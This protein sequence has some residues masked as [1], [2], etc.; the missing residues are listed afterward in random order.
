MNLHLQAAA[1]QAAGTAP[2]AEAPAKTRPV[3]LCDPW[4]FTP[5]YTAEL[6]R[7]LLDAGAPV[8]LLCPPYHPEPSFFAEQGLQ[9]ALG[10]ARLAA[11]L[12]PRR[13]PLRRAVRLVDAAVNLPALAAGL[14]RH[15][16]AILHLQQC[17]LLEHGIPADLLLVRWA[18][19]LGIPVVHT[20]HNLLPNRAVR[21][22][23]ALYG[24]FYRACDRLLCHTGE[25]AERLAVEFRVEA[26]R[27]DVVPHGPLFARRPA[28]TRG[29]CR[30]R[31]G[32]PPG[33]TVFLWQGVLVPYKG[34][35]LLLDAWR[36]VEAQSEG[37]A[38]LLIAGT[39]PAGELEVLRA[40]P[41]ANS[42][43][44]DLRYLPSRELP[45]YY[46]AAD[47]LLYPYERITTS[48]ALLTGLNY[49][50]PI[51]ASALPLFR[52]FLEH[53]ANALLFEQHTP[54]A[55][56]RAMLALV[57]SP[58]LLE[59]LRAGA[60]ANPARQTQWPAIAAQTLR[61][62]QAAGAR[63]SSGA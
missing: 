24:R 8:R 44:L 7:A 32:L 30:E 14:A 15:R 31:L 38:M 5:W 53:G 10:P 50:K 63:L 12:H 55:L 33:R 20:V 48:G 51:V 11:A 3:W 23:A 45:L 36:Q 43:R 22:S 61:S 57:H 39:G 28:L 19:A 58:A 42:V 9:T 29:E 2:A 26:G 59:R 52:G 41:L 35:P 18:R 60:R 56:A 27:I 54:D 49:Q 62:Y 46:E 16:P 1:G 25:A 47:V 6:A 34:L 17:P 21:G 4:C 37:K 40:L 13:A